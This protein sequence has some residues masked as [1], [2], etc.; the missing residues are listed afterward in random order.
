MS[1]PQAWKNAGFGV[2][3]GREWQAAG[4]NATDA[5]WWVACK[6]ASANLARSWRNMGVGIDVVW[7]AMEISLSPDAITAWSGA[8]GCRHRWLRDC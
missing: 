4:F 5:K 6:V 7:R 2:Q 1:T 3:E 8:H